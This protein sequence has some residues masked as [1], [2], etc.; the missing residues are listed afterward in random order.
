MDDRRTT[1]LRGGI[2][3]V[4]WRELRPRHGG[5]REARMDERD[6]PD[7][8]VFMMCTRPNVRAYRALPPGYH[9]RSCRPDELA[10]WRA[11]PFDDAAQAREYDA[12]MTRFFD[13]TYGDNPD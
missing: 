4:R 10:L 13:E 3:V 5:R 8:N 12:F 1:D 11:F 9:L 7:L 2:I 6:I